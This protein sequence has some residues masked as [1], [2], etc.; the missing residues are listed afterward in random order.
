MQRVR[1]TSVDL[2][3][4]AQA[5]AA[6]TDPAGTAV[7]GAAF[8]LL[9]VPLPW[10]NDIAD[11][12][13]VVAAADAIGATAARVQG[14]VP[15]RDDAPHATAVLYTHPG[16]PFTAYERRDA[17]LDV[18]DL[19]AGI[20]SL[21]DAPVVDDGARD[22]LVCTHG[23][24]DRCCGAMGT[25][26]A[27]NVTPRDGLHVRRTSHLGGHRFAPTAALF[28]EGTVWAWL[29]DAVLA[30]ILERS[31]DLATVLPH[32]RGSTALDE[33]AVQV[34][35]RA[36]FAEVGWSYLDTARRGAVVEADDTRS[37]VRIETSLGA[38]IGVVELLGRAPQPICGE[39]ISAAKKSDPVFRLSEF[40]SD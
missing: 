34:A 15:P 39:D 24:R 37:V 22:L 6:E 12:P 3:C 32:Y 17:C 5:R 18:G 8:L 38:W 7:A 27:M 25:L 11:H 4:S 21:A 31:G 28:P 10:P 23:A 2:R 16:G 13:A 9:E 33:P 1:T 29:D 14:V 19:A 40:R 20:A 30:S 36:V 35:E 26:L